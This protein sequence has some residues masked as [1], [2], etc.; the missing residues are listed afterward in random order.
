MNDVRVCVCRVTGG[1]DFNI[2][3]CI[4]VSEASSLWEVSEVGKEFVS[5]Q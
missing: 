5:W 4:K 1:H 3:K 2:A